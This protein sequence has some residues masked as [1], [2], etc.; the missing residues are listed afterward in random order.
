MCR[1]LVFEARGDRDG[2]YFSLTAFGGMALEVKAFGL[3]D[4]P[5]FE[6]A[7]ETVR[8]KVDDPRALR[9]LSSCLEEVA[10]SLEKRL[11]EV[12]G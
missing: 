11:K 10:K 5:L 4:W 2:A 6:G 3:A 8:I 12:E 1:G 7:A 9:S